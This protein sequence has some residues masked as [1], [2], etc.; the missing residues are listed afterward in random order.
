MKMLSFSH[1]KPPTQC[2]RDDL[3]DFVL[4]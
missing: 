2:S 4:L 3:A 1:H